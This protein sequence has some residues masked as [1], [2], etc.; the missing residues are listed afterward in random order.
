MSK[1]LT[2]IIVTL[3]LPLC[4][5]CG[6][7]GDSG[8]GPDGNSAATPGTFNFGSG[9]EGGGTGGSGSGASTG[10]IADGDNCGA[11]VY[12]GEGR[13]LAAM[14]VMDRSSSMVGQNPPGAT[15]C[16]SGVECWVPTAAAIESFVNSPEATGLWM[17]LQFFPLD[18][19]G[20]PDYQASC[21]AEGVYATPYVALA[22]LPSNAAAIEQAM[23]EQ[24]PRSFNPFQQGT[25]T[26]P[27]LQGG[28]TAA[29][30]FAIANPNFKTIVILS[31]DGAPTRCDP[32]DTPTIGQLAARG[33]NG[34]AVD[35]SGQTGLPTIETYVIG[36]GNIDGLNDISRAGGTGDAIILD[37]NDPAVSADLFFDAMQ[38]IR[39]RALPCDYSIP[40]L[41][42]GT[43]DPG[44]V[45][46]QYIDDQ[47]NKEFILYVESESAC[48]PTTGGWYYDDPDSPNRIYTCAST[49]SELKTTSSGNVA[50]AIGCD[51][52]IDIQ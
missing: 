7:D 3:V 6:S 17:G 22:E 4:A 5:A 9:G 47:N 48:D 11:T 34:E 30:R 19:P 49:C 24:D 38:Q 37:F 26:Y 33:L 12:G 1:H 14:V 27:A 10:T 20:M 45:N 50:V 43:F 23:T 41:T 8:A 31:T 35:G 44:K 52:K 46:L 29:Q 16:P 13:P 18:D 42:A 28:I 21:D 40:E 36:I 2:P 25:P 15:G 39:G 32:R 51:T